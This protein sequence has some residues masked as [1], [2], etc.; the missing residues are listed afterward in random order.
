MGIT[1]SKEDIHACRQ[2]GYR[3]YEMDQ[4]FLAFEEDTFNLIWC[5]HCLEHSI[6][7]SY[8]LTGFHRVLKTEGYLYIEVP[9]AETCSQHEKNPNHYSVLGKPMWLELMKR[10]NFQPLEVLD[11][12]L[13]VPAGPDTYWAFIL[14]KQT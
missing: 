13:Q 7:P 5:R 10:S 2:K 11:I 3:V 12:S 14:Q 6:F 9:A 8:T 4:S 1:L